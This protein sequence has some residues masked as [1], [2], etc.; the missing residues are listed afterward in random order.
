MRAKPLL[1]ALV[2]AAAALAVVPNAQAADLE[3]PGIQPPPQCVT[4]PCCF[5]PCP[6]P[7]DEC[8]PPSPV[9][10]REVAVST[11]QLFA[12][13]GP[14]AGAALHSDCSVDVWEAG[15][16]CNVKAV[17]THETTIQRDVGPVGASVDSCSPSVDC[18][19][20]PLLAPLALAAAAPAIEPP[21]G[22]EVVQCVT[23]PCPPQVWCAERSLD[24]GVLA[25]VDVET[26]C[27]VTVGVIDG[28]RV[29]TWNGLEHHQ[30]RQTAGPLTLV[31]NYCGLRVD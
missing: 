4:Q 20:P 17:P 15:L 8:P 21:V 5:A 3:P 22:V 6:P 10:C 29:C 14:H 9:R 25:G 18:T 11:S 30:V 1:L 31:V 13:M 7:C 19:C 27:E 12:Y 26:T 2:L 28:V 23:D 16:Q 24:G